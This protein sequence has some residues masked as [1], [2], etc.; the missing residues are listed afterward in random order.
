MNPEHKPVKKVPDGFN[1]YIRS[2]METRESLSD[3][4]KKIDE[5]IN[6]MQSTCPHEWEHVSSTPHYEWHQ[7]KHCLKNLNI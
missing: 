1:T 7:C 4:L 5:Q 3:Q 2:L 6:L